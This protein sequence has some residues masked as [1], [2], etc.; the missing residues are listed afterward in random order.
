[1]MNDFAGNVQLNAQYLHIGGITI[2]VKIAPHKTFKN[3]AERIEYLNKR[4]RTFTPKQ[5]RDSGLS[6]LFGKTNGELDYIIQDLYR[7]RLKAVT[8]NGKEIIVTTKQ[9]DR[10][11]KETPQYKTKVKNSAKNFGKKR[12]LG[13]VNSLIIHLTHFGFTVAEA[14]WLV[15]H[16]GLQMSRWRTQVASSEKEEMFD[17]VFNNPESIKRYI[18]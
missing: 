17:D 16:F 12:T 4:L 14:V 13:T 6:N 3:K 11:Y 9:A 1:M 2:L 8:H 15:N 5:K 10:L 18:E 7:Q